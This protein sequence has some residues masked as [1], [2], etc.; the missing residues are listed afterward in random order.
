METKHSEQS[1][2]GEDGLRN[3]V[4]DEVAAQFT[5]RAGELGLSLKEFAA[6]VLGNAS[7]YRP[8]SEPRSRDAAPAPAVV[9]DDPDRRVTYHGRFGTGEM[10]P[11][12]YEEH[13]AR[14][15][16]HSSIIT[17]IRKA[18]DRSAAILG[19][20][21]VVEGLERLLRHYWRGTDKVPHSRKF[22][23]DL[24]DAGGILS[25]FHSK[26]VIAYL[27]KVI[28]PE[29]FHDL[30]TIREIRNDFAHKMTVDKGVIDS[31][32]FDDAKR[33]SLCDGLKKVDTYSGPLTFDDGLMP[34]DSRRNRFL[35][36][37]I[38]L[39]QDLHVAATFLEYGNPEHELTH[40]FP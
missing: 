8:R 29:T 22:E 17:E 5:A 25:S 30:E 12:T 27:S 3:L 26:A 11:E 20:A 7:Q 19:S 35:I 6:K 10:T 14:R 38:M 40:Y 13:K 23:R 2:D 34:A 15:A 28:G 18:P 4:G 32:S 1:H 16:I 9:E 39:G 24:F 31:V 36:T 37:V 33:G 21:F